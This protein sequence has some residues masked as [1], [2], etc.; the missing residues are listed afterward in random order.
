[1][2]EPTD[3]IERRAGHYPEHVVMEALGALAANSGNAS[4]T[5]R[6]LV[7]E[8]LFDAQPQSVAENLRSWSRNKYA[9]Q[10]RDL[11]EKLAPDLE[12]TLA[13]SLL[14]RAQKAIDAQ[15]LA[16]DRA[17][18][19]LESGEDEDPSRTAANFARVA[20][21]NIDK[22]LALQGR[23]SRITE[24]RDPW[25]VLR[26]LAAKVPGLIELPDEDVTEV[27]PPELEEGED[28]QR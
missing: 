7:A 28:E 10:Y 3:L 1:M 25:E 13:N 6:E 22:R 27:P 24:V 17:V 9:K 16:I 5:A 21:T 8:G 14:E 12:M 19:R 20:Q 26:A 23:P 11:Q 2:S 18:E 4:L 15:E